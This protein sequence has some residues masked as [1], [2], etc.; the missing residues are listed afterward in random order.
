MKKIGKIL[1]AALT[2]LLISGSLFAV[3]LEQVCNQLAEHP[4]TKGDFEQL[5]TITTAKGARDLKS[6]GTFVF[7]VEGIMWNTLKPFPSKMVVTKSKIIQTDAKGNENVIDGKDNPTFASIASTIS[8]VFSNDLTLLKQNFEIG[9]TDNG[10]N[11]WEMKLTPKDSTISSVM[12]YLIVSGKTSGTTSSL[13]SIVMQE[14]S[15]N[16]IRYNFTNQSY[17]KELSTDEKVLFGIK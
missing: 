4:V 3:S 17:P 1:L 7:G 15:D 9:F 12:Q 5:K 10:N 14:S 6:S 11:T 13:D 16:K 2:G 8:A